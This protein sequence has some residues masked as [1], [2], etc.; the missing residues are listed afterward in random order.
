MGCSGG[1]EAGGVACV[2]KATGLSRGTIARGISELENPQDDM[3][4]DEVRR[5]ATGR[6]RLTETDPALLSDLEALVEPVTRGDSE[7]PLRWT[8]KS[9]RRLAAELKTQGHSVSFRTVATLL[10]ELGY[11]LQANMKTRE[12]KQHPDRTEQFEQ[13]NERVEDFQSRE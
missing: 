9:T 4:P 5:G 1:P 11:S 12:G 6:K 13:I 7:S 3:S 8:C 10:G 2:E